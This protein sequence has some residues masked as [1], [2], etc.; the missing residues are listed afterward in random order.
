M[1]IHRVSVG[2][3]G[4]LLCSQAFDVLGQESK[5]TLPEIQVIGEQAVGWIN[6][7][8][9]TASRLGVT[10]KEVPGSVEVLEREAI[11]EH[12]KRQVDEAIELSTGITA[13]ANG[14]TPLA[15]QSRG[16]TNNAVRYLYDGVDL[17]SANS[18]GR[19]GG[20]FNLDR[21]EVV[22]GLASV[23]YGDGAI[24][25]A[26]NFV[27]KS[28]SRRNDPV[29]VEVGL[30]S[31]ETARFGIGTGGII[32]D[33]K[34]YYRFDASGINSGSGAYDSGKEFSR[35]TGSLLFDVTDSLTASFHIDYSK[36]STKDFYFGT[37]LRN[38]KIDLSLKDINYNNITDNHFRGESTLLRSNIEWHPN[39]EWAIRNLAFYSVAHRD[40]RNLEFYVLNSAT[41]R[42]ARDSFGDLDHDQNVAGDRF[43]ILNK[44]KVFGFDNR[45]S[46]GFEVNI[47]DFKSARNGFAGSD[48]VDAYN[49]PV[50]SPVSLTG[51]QFRASARKV[52]F[53]KKSIFIDDQFNITESL[54]L[55]A[56]LR[57]D[58]ID[59]RFV[60]LDAG[61]LI[62]DPS[63]SPTSS[64]LGLVYDALP[65]LTLYGQ[66]GKGTEPV[67][68]LLLMNSTNTQFDLTKAKQYEVG[69]KST[70][71]N[72]QAEITTAI[73]EIEKTNVLTRDPSNPNQNI[74]VGKQ[75]S[76]GF[77]LAM[78]YRPS[79][80]W[81]FDGNIAVLRAQFD[82]FS[83]RV[84]GQ[85]IS[86]EGNV[87][88]DVPEKLANLGV[89][90]QPFQSW[91]AGG[92]GRYVGKRYAN[93]AN[94]VEMPAYTKLDLTTGYRFDKKTELAFWIRNAT[95]KYYAQWTDGS[96]TGSQVILGE[97][98]TF[99][100]LLRAKF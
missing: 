26:I 65:W 38:G 85:A 98:R 48:N 62:R 9:G 21:I 55:V 43:E 80:Q 79:S 100:L 6:L 56:G 25:G 32:A 51:V 3:L 91:Y 63:F 54:K 60:F 35:I 97:P 93:N 12:G 37:P 30:G 31:Y 41:N 76:R 44:S 94:T 88:M 86:R 69:T 13:A 96:N 39:N 16:F 27:T 8:V 78:A 74:P 1:N 18:T 87:P 73:Y 23:L 19:Q 57:H 66:Y 84:S 83:E 24:G 64:R 47:T 20:T 2:A 45:I 7:P 81:Y 10:A 59:T 52:D 99:E 68:T 92:Y 14:S 34:A 75:S 67:S 15:V 82:D 58:K 42:V 29:E 61:G 46:L 50:V 53:D 33:Q 22:R 49:P 95:N 89:R 70:F 77:E 5:V 90:F 28:P 71:L 72:G 4:I 11:V 40:W 36:D 17:G